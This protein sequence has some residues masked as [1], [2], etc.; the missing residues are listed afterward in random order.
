MSE[1][2]TSDASSADDVP[3]VGGSTEL[4]VTASPAK[5]NWRLA[6][7]SLTALGVVY[8]DIGTSP[9]YALRECFHGTHG[10][11]VSPD[12]V[13]GVLSLVFWSL[14]VVISIKYL[15]VILQAD[16]RGEGGILALMALAAPV[17]FASANSRRW[18]V[19]L[20]IVG[21]AMLYSDGVITPAISVLSAVEGLNVATH[22]FEPYAVP[23]TLA[24]LV[25]L[26]GIQSFGTGG[27]GR[28]FGPVMIV[29]F[30]TIA[31]LGIMSLVRYPAILASFNPL[32][33]SWFFFEHGWHGFMVL[34]SVFLVVTGGEALYADMGHFGRVPIRIAWF[35]I[36]FP[37]LL[38]NYLGQGA[39]L[40]TTP[41]AVDNPFFHL[42]PA[43]G[44]YPLVALSAVAA[45]IASQALISGAFSI[46]MQAIQLGLL[47]RMK[48]LHTSATEYGQIYM[49][50]INTLL[51]IGC[52][53]TVINFRSSNA[54]AAAYG[55]AITATMSITTIL[56]YMVARERWHWSKLFAGGVAGSFL[57]VDVAFLAANA[58]KIPDG[59]WLPIVAAAGIFIVMSTWRRGRQ[60]LGARLAE[61]SMPI[62][63]FLE[64]IAQRQPVRVS[65]TAVFMSGNVEGVP[66]AMIQNLGHNKVLHEHV[67]LLTVRTVHTPRVSDAD[68]MT[69]ESLN[70]P[71]LFRAT[72]LYG[73]MD[74]PDIPKALLQLNQPGLSF[75]PD[76]TTYFLGR[77][78]VLA[79]ANHQGMAVWREKL[80]AR[81]SHNAT[82]ATAYFCLPPDRVVELGSQVEI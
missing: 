52:L 9:L 66:P 53:F 24:I 75:A 14:I 57:V 15:L 17:K 1:E 51:M 78:S 25:G 72:V 3:N 40:I 13:F 2:S 70:F 38:L 74:D 44:L 79:S 59:G 4:D 30:A 68:R 55:I 67:L 32:Y 31:I 54:L 49:P 7:L 16:N 20:G 46:T 63:K 60:I 61:Q 5:Q 69:L 71:G 56:F 42:A 50:T 77:E 39:L 26:F 28:L 12:N 35:S 82:S 36:V 58:S 48:I 76:K 64:E 27:I 45:I 37:A 81:M 23:T 65:G 10:L 33:A 43:W 19:T 47:P 6:G 34:G 73:F 18:L 41:A 11:P 29:W 21:A 22:V 62:G 8:G 80:F